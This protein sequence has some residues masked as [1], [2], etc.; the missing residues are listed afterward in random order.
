[1]DPSR[2]PSL[3]ST[4]YAKCVP[5]NKPQL[6]IQQLDAH[7]APDNASRMQKAWQSCANG[8]KAYLVSTW[9]L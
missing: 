2:P 6:M 4:D 7:S 5:L 1:M 3:I 9:P 8:G